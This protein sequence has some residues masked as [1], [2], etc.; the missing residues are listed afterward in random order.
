MITSVVYV[1]PQSPT[2]GLTPY[3]SLVRS[4]PPAVEPVTL[5][6]AKHHCRVDT[7]DD[8]AYISSLIAV[9]REYV[10]DRLD[11][12]LITTVWE[13]RYDAFPIWELLLPRPPMQAA[14]VTVTY[15]NEGGSMVTITSVASQFQTDHRTTPGRIYPLYNGVWPAVRGDENSVTVQWTAGYGASGSAVPTTVKHA[16]LLLV[17]HWYGTREPVTTGTTAQNLPI[18]LTFETLM[19]ASGWGG[20]R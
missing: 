1:T 15:R 20:Y 8:D 9:A 11:V 19:A 2:I 6:E 14:N 10:E 7:T 4:T 18:P 5:A 3:R 16:I 17:A 13:A 12:T